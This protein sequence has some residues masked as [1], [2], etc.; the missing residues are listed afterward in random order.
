MG[1]IVNQK[2]SVTGP[3]QILDF[4]GLTVDSLAMELKKIRAESVGSNSPEL[5]RTFAV[6]L[7][8]PSS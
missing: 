1:F 4:L 7:H 6:C 3:S 2:N 8:P 5:I